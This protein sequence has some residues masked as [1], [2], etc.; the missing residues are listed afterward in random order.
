METIKIGD[1]F[2]SHTDAEKILIAYAISESALST[3]VEIV[4]KVHGYL[5]FCGIFREVKIEGIN[6]LGMYFYN[7]ISRQELSDILS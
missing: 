7:T 3:I 1:F 2:V 6:C 5:K 4:R